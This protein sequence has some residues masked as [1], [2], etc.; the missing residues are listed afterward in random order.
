M[1]TCTCRFFR[2]LVKDWTDC[3]EILCV[4]RDPLVWCF[5]EVNGVVQVHVRTAHPFSM[6]RERLDGLCYAET[7]CVVRG[8]LAIFTHDGDVRMSASVTVH[9]FRHIRSHSFIAQKAFY[10]YAPSYIYSGFL[11]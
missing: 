4:V 5:T 1:S 11:D 3:A 8:P 7:W 2:C 6:S 10:W 9:T